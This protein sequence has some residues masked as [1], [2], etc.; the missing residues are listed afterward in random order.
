MR[1]LITGGLGY[2]GSRLAQYLVVHTHHT[3]LLGTRKNI[4]SIDWLPQVKVVTTIWNSSAELEN[5]CKN[6]DIVIH[7]AGM[8][9][10]DCSKNP[11]LAMEVNS[12]ATERLLQSSIKQNVKRFIYLSSAHVYDN[13]LKGR[14]NEQSP[15]KNFHPYAVSHKAGEDGV[16]LAHSKGYIEGVVI[17][18]SNSFGPPV[19]LNTNCW[20]LV[21][22]DLCKQAIESNH[23]IV[24]TREMQR[25]DFISLKN[26]CR[27]IEFLINLP[28]SQLDD[29]LF[30][31]GGEWSPTIS[32]VAKILSD[33][34]FL[35]LGRR[36]SIRS[37]FFSKNSKPLELDFDISKIKLTGFELIND[38][39]SE[40]DDL[41]QFCHK[42]F[43]V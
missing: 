24:K 30:N 42:S 1:I 11:N 9:A 32:E 25:R 26:A 39:N 12:S 21:T 2:L 41:I 19:L 43:G 18:L 4:K 13:P 16:R 33:R 38:R 5:I 29:G 7:L 36:I 17:R 40:F 3:I 23:M 28:F 8:N 10:S 34:I 35:L 20:S 14:I 15:I 27:A 6:V 37:K 31:V 22:N